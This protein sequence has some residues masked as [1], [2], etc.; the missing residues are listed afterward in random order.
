MPTEKPTAQTDNLSVINIPFISQQTGEHFTTFLNELPAYLWVE[1]F[2]ALISFLRDDL[3]QLKQGTLQAE[4]ELGHRISAAMQ[5]VKSKP[6]V[7]E[8][9]RRAQMLSRAAVKGAFEDSSLIARAYEGLLREILS[10][11]VQGRT[12]FYKKAY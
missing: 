6:K 12:D 7:A 3:D 5:D 1:D 10:E 11:I 9:N 8:W 4:S 2:S